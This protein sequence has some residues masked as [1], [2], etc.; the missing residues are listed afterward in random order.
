M[1]QQRFLDPIVAS[2]PSLVGIGNGTLSVDRLTHFTTA[3]VYTLTCIAKSPSTIFSVV[4]SLDGAVGLATVGTQ[5]YDEDLKI[6]LTITQGSTPFEVGDVFTVG[7]QNGTDLN[8]DNIDDYDEEPQKNFGTGNKGSMSGDHNIRFDDTD[9]LAKVIVQGLKIQAVA[10][11]ASLLSFRMYD[12]VPAVAATLSINGF[13]FTADV[14][15]TGGNAIQIEFIGD[16]VAGFESVNVIGNLIEIHVQDGISTRAQ[17]NTALL[18]SAP[19]MALVNWTIDSPTSDP[20]AAPIAATN[21]TNGAD[22][23]GGAGSEVAQLVGNEIRVYIGSGRSTITAVAA[24]MAASGPVNAVAT[25]IV[26]GAPGA[27]AF[28]MGSAVPLLSGTDRVFALNKQELTES[29]DFFEGNGDILAKDGEFQGDLDVAGAAAFG[30]PVA[31]DFPD[32][33][34]KVGDA[35]QYINYLIQNS[36][37]ALRTSDHTK[38]TWTKPDLI[39]TADICIEFADTG[40][41]NK[42]AAANSPI[43]IPDGSS[44]YVILDRTSTRYVL[45][46]VAATM[47]KDVNAFRL[48]TR[49]GD[50]ALLWD[51]TLVRDGKSVRI[52]EGGEGGTVKVDLIDPIDTT[53]PTGPSATIDGVSV[54]EGMMILFTN[55]TTGNNRVYKATG[56]GVSLV[57]ITQSVWTNGL[58][59]I[60]GDDVIVIQGEAFARAHGIFDGTDFLFND[61]VRYFNGVDYWEVSN[62]KQVSLLD[63]QAAFADAIVFA[64]LGSENCFIDYSVIR[65]GM[66]KIG[67]LAITT[68]GVTV[69]MSDTGAEQV[70]ALGVTFDADISG[71]DLRVRYT[72]TSSGFPATMKFVLRRWSDTVG[73]PGGVPSYSGGSSTVVAAGADTQIQFND[74]GNLGA[75]ADFTWSKA[76]NIMIKAGLQ[77]SGMNTL[78]LPDATPSGIAVS[79]DT[80]LYPSFIIEYSI[81]RDGERRTGRIMVSTNGVDVGFDDEW[82]STDTTD[83]GV[84]LS[85]SVVGA[86]VEIAFTTTA[87]SVDAQLRYAFRR[88]A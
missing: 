42:I 84:T 27:L 32:A 37:I 56:V 28:L 8:Q 45:P 88:W 39:F 70:P 78:T 72:T 15:G 66:K 20:V 21:L 64:F 29:G 11:G 87:T 74:G 40:L 62:L 35:Q 76:S 17:V 79:M 41:S 80:T 50:N 69:A 52:G 30:G 81:L 6:F 18:A 63:N 67:T 68:D 53:L 31:L 5:F 59:P 55:L 16:V 23:L 47:P 7:V 14:A 26:R 44:V 75:D 86:N 9:Q 82:T 46:I 38:V 33:G 3:Q 48:I 43:S 36:K 24:A 4:G 71:S 19:A 60:N 54:T 12:T 83:L 13:N 49:Y 34:E 77:E 25:A 51:N 57:W 73:G 58:D 2:G 85:A 22:T 1:A 61:R 65:N 10:P